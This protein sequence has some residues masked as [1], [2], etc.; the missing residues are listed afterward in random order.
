MLCITHLTPDRLKP[1]PL[2]GPDPAIITRSQ[3]MIIYPDILI[4]NGHL[5]PLITM[6][7][8]KITS[9]PDPGESFDAY[10]SLD[11]SLCTMTH[12]PMGLWAYGPLGLCFHRLEA[13]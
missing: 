3:I 12:G 2:V 13:Q 7:R 6:A 4:Q 11:I 9:N 5:A 8:P 10:L 1:D